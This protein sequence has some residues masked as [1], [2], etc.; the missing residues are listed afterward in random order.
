MTRSYASPPKDDSRTSATDFPSKQELPTST[1]FY[2]QKYNNPASVYSSR[3]NQMTPEPKHSQ[4]V[5]KNSSTTTK[6]YEKK[7]TENLI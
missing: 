2:E 5:S 6:L 7:I 1:T 3:Y 4:S